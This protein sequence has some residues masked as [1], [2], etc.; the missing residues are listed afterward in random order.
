M[1]I[2]KIVISR[3]CSDYLV[4]GE[5]IQGLCGP[6]AEQ[7]GLELHHRSVASVCQCH[8]VSMSS[9]VN[10]IMCQCHHVSMSSCVISNV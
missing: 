8:H 5:D 2:R 1:T 3:Q 4:V 6:A 7:Y 10:V 9:C